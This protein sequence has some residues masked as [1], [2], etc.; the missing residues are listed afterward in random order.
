MNKI[1]TQQVLLERMFIGSKYA[2]PNETACELSA[3]LG[4]DVQFCD[5]RIDDGADDDEPEDCYVMRATFDVAHGKTV[6]VY[7]GDVTREIGYITIS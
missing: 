5:S 6:R 1:K 3:L 2:G 4:V 7:Y